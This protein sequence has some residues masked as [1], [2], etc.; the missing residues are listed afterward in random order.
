MK[1]IIPVALVLALALALMIVPAFAETELFYTYD[2]EGNFAGDGLP[3]AGIEYSV[4]V[5]CFDGNGNELNFSGNLLITGSV[6]EFG[7]PALI[8]SL[9]GVSTDI[10]SDLSFNFTFR[11][12]FSEMGDPI[13]VC[14]VNCSD[15]DIS[16]GSLTL[17]PVSP[18]PIDPEPSVPGISPEE[19]GITAMVESVVSAIFAVFSAIG[20]WFVEFLPTLTAI[21][22]TGEALT[23][24]GV[25]AILG[26]G[27]SVIFLLINVIRRFMNFGR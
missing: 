12:S 13:Y 15:P 25:L 18:A 20:D 16:V 6:D 2:E 4:D 10:F 7:D 19:G 24:I 1:K 14:Q 26:L 3:S 17:T 27:V 21:F 9:T 11:S 5:V 22:W 8:G 23:F